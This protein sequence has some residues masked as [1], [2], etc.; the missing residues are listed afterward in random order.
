[1]A[2]NF[3]ANPTNLQQYSDDNGTVWEF[4][5]TKGVWN[6]LADDRL[7]EFSGVKLVL[8]S[9][10]SLIPTSTA[11]SWDSANFDIGGY[12]NVSFPTRLTIPKIGFYRLNLLISV[13]ALGNGASY[14]FVVKKNGTINL[15]TTVAG[16]NQFVSYDEILQ[17]YEGDY[18]ELY[19]LEAEGVGSINAGSFFEA[20]NI[21]DQIGSAQSEATTFSGLKS[22]LDIAEALTSSFAPVTW[23]STVFN[24]NADIN[25]NVYWSVGDPSK[26]VIYTTGYY[27]IKASFEAGSTGTDDSYE[28][29]LR[30]NNTSSISAS[31]SPNGSLDIDDVFNLT[32]GSYIQFFAAESGGVG[33]LTTD[34][35]F[36]LIRLGV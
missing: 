11:I 9:P 14:T 6:V 34:S 21:G 27:R 1:M 17:L 26:A 10:D 3:P 16:A 35:Y 24:T 32:S 19:G 5:S 15:T 8:G 2:L 4:L 7:K 23:D 29:D 12:F 18:I 31:M 13:G 36:E 33:E 25:G 28:V 20:Q 30:F 22:N